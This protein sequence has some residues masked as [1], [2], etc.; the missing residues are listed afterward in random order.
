MEP[1]DFFRHAAKAISDLINQRPWSPT[2]DE[3][4]EVIE[5]AWWQ[6]PAIFNEDFDKLLDAAIKR[7]RRRRGKA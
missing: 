5:E 2:V 3:I 6:S 1:D 4:A 7:R